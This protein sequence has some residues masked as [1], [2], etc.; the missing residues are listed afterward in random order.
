MRLTPLCSP[1]VQQSVF[2]CVARGA[3]LQGA[4]LTT[5]TARTK[6]C[7]CVEK[8]K[9]KIV[10]KKNKN[11]KTKPYWGCQK[12]LSNGTES[13]LETAVLRLTCSDSVQGR[14]DRLRAP[15]QHVLVSRLV[16]VVP[17]MVEVWT[18]VGRRYQGQRA[19]VVIRVQWFLLNADVVH[20][21][22]GRASWAAVTAVAVS[23]VHCSVHLLTDGV[24]Q[25]VEGGTSNGSS[26][27]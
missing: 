16:V 14:W 6:T 11:K 9:Q 3:T 22:Q 20:S 26:S 25:R 5:K 18:V 19:I 12:S 8:N 24:G 17:V 21:W 10:K 23:M 2:D 15:L 4:I 1:A 7:P 13:S 27:V